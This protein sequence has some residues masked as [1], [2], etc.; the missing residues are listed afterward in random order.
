MKAT[1]TR[2]L[3]FIA[4]LALIGW[5][6]LPSATLSA[7]AAPRLLVT[8][9]ATGE[10]S[11]PTPPPPTATDVGEQPRPS[12]TPGPTNTPPPEDTP[13][14]DRPRP[15][16]TPTAPPASPTP[17]PTAAVPADPAI[18]KSVNPG[19][20]RVGDTVEYTI[21]VTNLGGSVASGVVVD[22]TLPSFV[23]PTSATTTRGDVTISGQ[24]VR[25]TIGDLGPGETV[26]I[27]VRATVV[28]PATPPNNRNLATV[29][30][31]TP[32]G[33]PNNNQASVPLDTI[34][35]PVTLPNTSDADAGLLPIAAILLGLVLVAASAWLHRRAA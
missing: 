11:T 28:A 19:A 9:T 8:E 27:T 33:N 22:D 6:A 20:A 2:A 15:T 5:G 18:S 10:P 30:S 26:T 32:D 35:A 17:V 34:D 1:L 21:S 29:S 12:D 16:E 23:R 24:T 25:A 14:P 3:L 31:T 13:R 4:G 7:V